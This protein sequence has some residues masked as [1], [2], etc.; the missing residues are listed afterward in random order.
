MD[1]IDYLIAYDNY[2]PTLASAK[3]PLVGAA[4]ALWGT[5]HNFL[6]PA[7]HLFANP[8]PPSSQSAAMSTLAQLHYTS[9]SPSLASLCSCPAH[10]LISTPSLGS[11]HLLE[12]TLGYGTCSYLFL[13]MLPPCPFFRNW[14]G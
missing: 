13:L 3:I 14:I 7:P 10:A 12:C 8:F 5:L 4:S 1:A 9:K 6:H 2:L 11:Q